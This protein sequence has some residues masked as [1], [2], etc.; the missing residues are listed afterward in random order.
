MPT[1]D[2]LGKRAVLQHHREI[3]FHLLK[4]DKSA[5]AGDPDSGN[6]VVHGDNLLGLK[7]LLPRYAGQVKC[8]YIDPPY[9]TG[10]EGWVYNDAVNSPEMRAWLGK[11]VG[12]EAEDLSRHD[13]WLS[14]MYP[15]LRLLKELLHDDGSIFVSIDDNSVGYLRLLMDEIFSPQRFVATLVWQKRYSRE[16]RA[17]IGDV[18]EYIL[19]YALNPERFKQARNRVPLD[20]KSAAVYKNPNN[21]PRGRWRPIPM[22]AQGFRPNQ[23]YKIVTPSGK[24]VTPPP[25]RCWSTIES[26][27]KQ[28]KA[29]G[30][31][32]FG[33]N[34]DS[35]P[36]IIRYLDEVEGLVPWTW[37]PH[38]EVG[39]TDEA[40]KEMRPFAGDDEAFPTPKPER[41]LKRI[42]E[43]ATNPGDLV[44]DSFAGSGTTG[45]VAHKMGRRYV[46]CEM[47]DYA[48]TLVA[49]R[50]SAVVHGQDSG[51]VTATTQWTG[52]G[53]FQ[54]CVLGEP[55]FD[56]LGSVRSDV[57]YGDLAAHVYFT[58]TGTPLPR[59]ATKKS[60]QLGV[61]DGVAVYLLFNGVLGDDRAN[62]G[63]VLTPG[64]LAALPPHNGP[65][66]IYAES[67]R[68]IN[69]LRLKREK[70]TFKQTPYQIKVY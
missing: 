49:K 26:E 9:N 57:S 43:V 61:H 4:V 65:K 30:R 70:I 34:G 28:L 1:L 12:R 64:V 13:K 63:N 59:R 69:D 68:G 38:D 18:H 66:V 55:L 32:W 62:G 53:G 39:H 7:A 24:V 15:R 47:E 25:G 56:D 10:N 58:E 45:A 8:I 5:S 33:K 46:L 19:V 16:N 2:W 52:G 37:W 36:S 51:G 6:L 31:M 14:M 22:T 11:V 67:I 20:D 44:L 42:L 29:D 27:F 48:R 23:M 3:P 60:P 35:Q 50:L 40:K 17:A 21:D 54:Y 41:L